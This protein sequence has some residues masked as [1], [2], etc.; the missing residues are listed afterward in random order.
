[1]S[2]M[3]VRLG[4]GYFAISCLLVSALLSAEEVVTTASPD[5]QAMIET[6]MNAASPGE[7]HARLEVFVGSWT[8]ISRNWMSAD[9]VAVE[10]TGVSENQ[11][12]LGGRFV[13]QRFEG[14]FMDQPFTG[15]GYTGYDKGKKAYVGTWMDNMGTMIM[16]SNGILDDGGK[17]LKFVTKI[18][19][20]I[21]GKPFEI[22]QKITITDDDHHTLEVWMSGIDGKRFK[23]TEINYTRKK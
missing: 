1:M 21:N 18:N 11:W 6:W 10:S 22:E 19:D 16:S 2:F 12:I 9:A 23:T 14:T 5:Q 7:M 20:P 4:L 15:V 13:E 17:A 3:K 8:A